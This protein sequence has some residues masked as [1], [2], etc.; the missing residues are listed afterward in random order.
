MAARSPTWSAAL[1]VV[2]LAPTGEQTG[3]GRLGG[4]RSPSWAEGR[5][6]PGSSRPSYSCSTRA[7][8]DPSLDDLGVACRALRALLDDARDL[9]ARDLA[10]PGATD[11]ASGLDTDELAAGSTT[12]GRR[13]RPGGRRLAAALPPVP[14]TCRRPAALP[15]LLAV[16]ALPGY[17]CRAA[18]VA[19]IR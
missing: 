13:S 6:R 17:G 7:A 3:L 11:A 8:G 9:D 19:A 18:S 1:D 14:T 4:G 5:A 15:D 10:P 16:F 2:A 12:Y